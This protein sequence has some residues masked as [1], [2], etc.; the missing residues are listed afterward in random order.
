DQPPGAAQLVAEKMSEVNEA[1][2][3]HGICPECLELIYAERPE[4][5]P[6]EPS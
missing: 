2:L 4:L 5:R 3:S 1:E 6:R